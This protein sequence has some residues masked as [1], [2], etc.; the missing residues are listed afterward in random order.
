[1]SACGETAK[2]KKYTGLM[3]TFITPFKAHLTTLIN[4]LKYAFNMNA[5]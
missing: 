3:H 2:S 5:L 4:N 1:M